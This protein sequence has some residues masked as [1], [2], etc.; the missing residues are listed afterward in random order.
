M[1]GHC[2]SLPWGH[3]GSGGVRTEVLQNCVSAAKSLPRPAPVTLRKY[4]RH[5]V[6]GHHTPFREYISTST[7]AL[8]KPEPPL[9]PDEPAS[10]H[11][12]LCGR[13]PSMAL[14]SSVSGLELWATVR[15][16]LL[17]SSVGGACRSSV[18][19]DRTACVKHLPILNSGPKSG[20]DSY[21]RAVCPFDVG[22][23]V[24][25]VLFSLLW[26]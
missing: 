13:G 7:K 14:L 5:L 10:A 19:W 11:L 17:P 4:R 3:L 18:L 16:V 23:T 20:R 8:V 26:R 21:T 6:H 25:W 22:N 12:A 1:S 9:F 24:T 2:P 15:T